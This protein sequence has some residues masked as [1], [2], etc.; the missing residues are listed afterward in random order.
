MWIVLPD[1]MI[2]PV[3]PDDLVIVTR[4]QTFERMSDEDETQHGFQIQCFVFRNPR[5][6]GLEQILSGLH[7]IGSSGDDLF[8]IFACH[9]LQT[10]EYCGAACLELSLV[11]IIDKFLQTNSNL[12]S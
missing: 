6:D 4:G 1:G 12:S 11:K 3:F 8:D 5:E 9:F 10:F 2:F 7:G